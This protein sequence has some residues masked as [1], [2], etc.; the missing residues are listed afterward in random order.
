MEEEG[1]DNVL[2]VEGLI[3]E[4]QHVNAS[5]MNQLTKWVVLQVVGLGVDVLELTRGLR[6]LI[7]IWMLQR[8]ILFEN[9]KFFGRFIFVLILF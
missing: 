8:K 1:K 4:V 7:G 5:L 3:Q 9:K 6:L 2:L